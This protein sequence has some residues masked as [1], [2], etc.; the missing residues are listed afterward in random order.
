MLD[1][2]AGVLV[3]GDAFRTAN[4]TP[5]LPSSPNTADVAEAKRSIVKLGG[6]PFETLLV[7]HGHPITAGCVGAHCGKL[8]AAG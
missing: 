8:G 1:P 5:E 7:G 6:L 3:A 2:I 4:G